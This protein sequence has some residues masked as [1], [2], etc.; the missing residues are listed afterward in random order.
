MLLQL[1][2]N[3]INWACRSSIM[4]V[5]ICGLQINLLL[6]YLYVEID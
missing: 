1:D 2:C 4:D 3:F 5:V 6:E